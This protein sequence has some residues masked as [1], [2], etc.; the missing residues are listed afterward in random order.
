MADAPGVFISYSQDSEEHADRVLALA[1][2]LFADGI[3]VILDRYVHPAPA[4]GWPHWMGSNLDAA[5]FVLMI[6][7]ETYRRCVMGLEEPGK[8]TGVRWEGKLIYNRIC[9]D[10][11]AGAQFIPILLPG[12]KPEHIPDAVRGHNRY[13]LAAFDLSDP[14]YEALYRHLTDQPATPRPDLGSI[15]KLPPKP[16][17]QPSPSPLPKPAESDEQKRSKVLNKLKRKLESLSSEKIN[18]EE[19]DEPKGLLVYLHKTL[20]CEFDLE[21]SGLEER[22]V[23]FLMEYR[24][25]TLTGLDK[26]YSLICDQNL[27]TAAYRIDEIIRLVLPFQLPQEL[28]ACVLEE[29]KQ[30][31]TV[32]ANAAPGVVFAEAVAARIAGKPIRVSLDAGGIKAPSRFGPFPIE[33]PPLDSPDATMPSL[34]RDLFL[35]VHLETGRTGD[36]GKMT[37]PDMMFVLRG[38]FEWWRN[39]HERA[40][41]VVVR[42]PKDPNDRIN[43]ER[44]LAQ[45]KE[46]VEHVMFLEYYTDPAALMVEGGLLG[47]LHTH[48]DSE[49]KWKTP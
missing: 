27:K 7:T 19:D 31:R 39:H 10:K 41:Y 3:D 18:D 12:S 36:A 17:P 28:C 20:R 8:G 37:V 47:F 15:K 30:G 32:L 9:Y 42:M 16:R 5:K 44:A 49:R 29:H 23:A 11:P 43:Y 25:Y 13:V 35:R 1:D 33:P 22:L 24:P 34:V 21:P 4:E 26:A 48:R 45:I 2:A 6:C 38:F 14:Q 46:G 40:P